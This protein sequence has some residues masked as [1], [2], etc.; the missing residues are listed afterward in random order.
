MA[1]KKEIILDNGIILNYHRIITL[2]LVTNK[3]INITTLSYINE[4][5]RNEDVLDDKVIIT[6][7]YTI[8]NYEEDYNIKRAYEYLK[9][10]PEFENSEDV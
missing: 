8:E 7:V 5:T 10:L 1:L 6:N 3:Y 9:T 2:Q 4:E